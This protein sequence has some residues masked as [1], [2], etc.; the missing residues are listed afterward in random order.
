M[1]VPIRRMSVT[2]VALIGAVVAALMLFPVRTPG[3][4]SGAT[5]SPERPGQEFVADSAIGGASPRLA[6]VHQH[7]ANPVPPRTRLMASCATASS[8]GPDLIPSICH[9]LPSAANH[10]PG[11]DVARLPSVR[12]PPESVAERDLVARLVP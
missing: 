7:P 4:A 12:A 1:L 8:G 5:R 6:S 9:D 2:T 11:P 10:V 3:G